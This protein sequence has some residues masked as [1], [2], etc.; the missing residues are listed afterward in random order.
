LRQ[1]GFEPLEAEDAV[2]ARRLVAD[3]SPD[4]VLM[5]WMLPG[6]SG[7]EMTRELKQGELTRELPVIMLTARGEEDD[8]VRGLEC[9][10]DDYVTKPFSPRELI[11]RI[12]ALLRRLAPHATEEVV[13][14]GALRLDPASHRVL[15]ADQAVELGPT[16][17]RLLHFFMT[18][19]DKVYSRTR[20][21]DNVWGTNVYIEE[22]TVDV[23]IRRLRKALEP[24]GAEGLV[25]TVRGAGYR[26]SAQA[27]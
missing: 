20:L 18:H 1:A 4:L 8:K 17:F 5:D 27:Q 13:E 21:L 23:H 26:F 9:G 19:P 11:A 22:R 3:L 6:T 14:A 10:A 12:R 24:F 15:V 25:Q 2:A 16:E 7:I